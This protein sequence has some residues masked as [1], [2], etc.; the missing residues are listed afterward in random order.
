[1]LYLFICKHLSEPEKSQA[2][3][4]GG[5]YTAE[6]GSSVEPNKKRKHFFSSVFE[7]SGQ[8]VSA[9]KQNEDLQELP[10]IIIN[11]PTENIFSYVA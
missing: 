6:Y 2:S 10:V 4:E 5:E 8:S 7:G 9:C 11:K 1:M 3:N